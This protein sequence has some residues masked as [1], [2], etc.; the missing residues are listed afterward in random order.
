MYIY[1]KRSQQN[2]W[3]KGYLGSKKR[4]LNTYLQPALIQAVTNSLYEI[5][6]LSGQLVCNVNTN[7]KSNYKHF[8]TIPCFKRLSVHFRNSQETTFFDF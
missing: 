2:H 1:V 8:D 6:N 4:E 5:L 7:H 3:I